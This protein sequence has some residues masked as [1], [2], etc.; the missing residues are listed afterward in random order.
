MGGGLTIVESAGGKILGTAILSPEQ[1]I[2]ARLI[3]R[4]PDQFLDVSLIVH[5]L[6]VALS[7]RNLWYPHDCYRWIYGDSDG[8][9]GL[10]VDRFA[11]VLVVQ[12]SNTAMELRKN[13]II[14][15][16]LKVA[17]PK[18]I[19]LKNNGKLR[20]MEGLSEYVEIVHGTLED[21]CAPMV[22]NDTRFMA[23]VIEGQKT[24]WFYDHRDNRAR[25]NQLVAGKRVL[26]V[27]SYI[28]GWG[29][30]A[31]THGASEVHCIDASAQALD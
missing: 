29:I 19:V 31:A 12:I 4:Q 18:V 22:E 3:S 25:L 15:A 16:L 26:D 7:S 30:Q 21:G 10:V 20:Q 28:G 2:C 17:K 6:K 11:D 1:L 27:F 13:D 8:L 23:P 24:G 9:P 5:R 14:D